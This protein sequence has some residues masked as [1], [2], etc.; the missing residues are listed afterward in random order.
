MVQLPTRV[1]VA[2]CETQP[3]TV[4]G[5]RA[6]LAGCPDLEFMHASHSLVTGVDLLRNERPRTMLLDKAFGIHSIV[7]WMIDQR[8]VLVGTAVAVWGVS[9]NEAE[10]L[11]FIQAGAKG[12]IRKTAAATALVNCLRS[13]ANGSTWMEDSIFRDSLRRPGYSHSDLTP[14]E[15]QV[16]TLVEQGLKNSEI[17]M[18]LGIRPGTVKIHLKHIFEKTGVRDRY[19]LALSGIRQKSNVALTV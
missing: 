17:A 2:V 9:I 12:V 11:R 19:G 16:L 5:I 10:A 8:Q 18:E 1:T 13:I 15:L 4:E 7:Q 3:V 14:R 6:V